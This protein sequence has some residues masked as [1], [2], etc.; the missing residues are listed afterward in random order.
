MEPLK[1]SA[2]PWAE[3]YVN[4]KKSG[5]TPKVISHIPAGEVEVRLVN[6]G[7]RH[8]VVRTVI[9][10]GKQA[11][12]SHSFRIEDAVKSDEKTMR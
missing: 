12:I 7:Y 6:P 9:S 1:I 10:P 4:G 5:I 11:R 8:H 3:I 2:A